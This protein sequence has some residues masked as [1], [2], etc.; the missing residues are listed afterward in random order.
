MT[1]GHA[2]LGHRM[3]EGSQ[4]ILWL[5]PFVFHLRAIWVIFEGNSLVLC[6]RHEMSVTRFGDISSTLQ[7]KDALHFTSKT[8]KPQIPRCSAHWLLYRT[9]QDF[10]IKASQ[11]AATS[12]SSLLLYMRR[13]GYPILNLSHEYPPIR[14][15]RALL[16]AETTTSPQSMEHYEEDLLDISLDLSNVYEGKENVSPRQ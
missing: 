12:W 6:E 9:G 15:F 16:Y 2:I 14:N 13:S 1:P 4:V 5:L 10:R 8:T 11:N 7:R 3:S